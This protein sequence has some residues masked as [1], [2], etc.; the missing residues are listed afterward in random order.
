MRG[1]RC[2]GLSPM[3]LSAALLGAAPA[4]AENAPSPAAG[5]PRHRRRARCFEQ[6][7]R[8][9]RQRD[10]DRRR[11]D[12]ARR[13]AR[14]LC[15]PAVFRARGLRPSQGIELRRQRDSGQARRADLRGQGQAVRQ[16]QAEGTGADRRRLE[17]RRQ[18]ASQ[19]SE[20]R[21]RP[22]RRRRR[23]LRR[24]H[25]LDGRGDE[26]EVEGAAHPCGRLQQ[27]GR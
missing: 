25:L 3:L 24:R 23:H 5:L 16:D 14:H 2:A 10:Q 17:R 9:D 8:Q 12:G 20:P 19:R 1:K 11:E 18:G 15:G 21:H 6:H 27:Q 13:R 26:G 7:E 22:H 4:A